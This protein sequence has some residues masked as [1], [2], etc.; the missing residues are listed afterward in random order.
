MP[1]LAALIAAIRL[2][3][4]WASRRPPPSTESLVSTVKSG[5]APLSPNDGR[6]VGFASSRPPYARISGRDD[7]AMMQCS[8]P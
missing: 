8:R 5:V 7:D 4:L 3:R 2:S 1:E 6:D